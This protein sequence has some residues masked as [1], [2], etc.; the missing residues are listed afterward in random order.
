MKG[1]KGEERRRMIK[2]RYGEKMEKNDIYKFALSNYKALNFDH[3]K[4]FWTNI[5]FDPMED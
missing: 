2:K 3:R 1:D 5:F 4:F